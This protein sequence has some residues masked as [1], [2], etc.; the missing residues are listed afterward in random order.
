M[1]GEMCE[2]SED[3]RA[4]H[5]FSQKRIQ[6]FISEVVSSSPKLDVEITI[7]KTN[8]IMTEIPDTRRVGRGERETREESVRDKNEIKII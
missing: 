7:N 5:W 1:P 6:L 3:P 2:G 4:P 8:K